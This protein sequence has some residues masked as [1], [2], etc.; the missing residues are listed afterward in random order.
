[1]RTAG[2][3]QVVTKPRKRPMGAS[4]HL[5]GKAPSA[6][7]MARPMGMK[8][9]LDADKEKE[10]PRRRDERSDHDIDDILA[11]QFQE[12]RLERQGRAP[13]KGIT[14]SATLAATTPNSSS[15]RSTLTAAISRRPS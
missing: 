10:K 15:S 4:S 2:S 13:A 11:G 5:C 9:D 1:M 7:P 12:Q 14:A 3:L 8:P 6:S